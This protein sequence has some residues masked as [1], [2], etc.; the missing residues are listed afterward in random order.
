MKTPLVSIIVPVYNQ[1][2]FLSECVKSVLGQTYPHFELILVNDGS[3]DGSGQL[4]NFFSLNNARIQ[5][6]HQS[7]LG[8][9]AARNTGIKKAKGKYICLLDSDDAMRADRLE[10]LLKTLESN[11][12]IDVLYNAIHVTDEKGKVLSK[13]SSPPLIPE[14]F[15]AEAFF[16]NQIPSPSTQI[17]KQ[18]CLK[19][20]AFNTAYRRAEDYEWNLRAAHR[21]RFDYL[22]L[23]LTFYRRHQNNSSYHLDD[24]RK[25]E[26]EILNTYGFEHIC[27]VIDR[28]YVNEKQLLKGKIAYLMEHYDQ[29]LSILSPLESPLAL[30]YLGNC[31]Y[32]NGRRVE[33]KECYEHGNQSD[34]ALLNNLGLC[35]ASLKQPDKALAC[36][37]KALELKKGY[38][39]PQKNIQAIQIG[40][41]LQA[42]TRR[43]LRNDLLPYK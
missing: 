10:I 33:A 2:Q 28:S 15:L 8:P 25:A 43:E 6:I 9:S 42:F 12:A 3:T 35:Y 26:L 24:L 19:E 17:M 29:A 34:P 1:G 18:E 41:Q 39:D 27:S 21:Y 22:D 38:Q 31:H 7:N 30:F 5:T 32:L 40:I 14:N 36:F 4:C 23:P 13:M 16:R 37:T 20:I 11:S